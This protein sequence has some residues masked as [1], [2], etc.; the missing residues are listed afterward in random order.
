MIFKHIS[1]QNFG[2]FNGPN[3]LNVAPA[4]GKRSVVLIGGENGFGKTTLL[5]GIKLCLYG[6]RA[7]ELWGGPNLQAYRAYI[8]KLF[9]E[10]AFKDGQREMALELSLVVWENRIQHELTVRRSYHLTDG[11]QFQSD[12]QESLEVLRDGKRLQIA[13]AQNADADVGN[14][15]DTL[16]RVL[17]PSHFAQ[18]YFF[19]AE[20][21][22]ELF[23]RPKPED[24]ARAVRD[25]L[26]L[27]IYERLAADMKDYRRVKV[28]E[29]YGK[30]AKKQADLTAKQAELAQ[31]K[32]ELA[33]LEDEITNGEEEL[34]DLK[35]RIDSKESEF[36][37]LGGVHQSQVEQLRTELAA[38]EAEYD[39]LTKQLKEA[40]SGQIAACFLL[41]L[42]TEIERRI[43][44]ERTSH[45]HDLKRDSLV[46]Q[47]ARL[48]ERLFGEHAPEPEPPLTQH[49]ASFYSDRLEVE[50]KQLFEPPPDDYEKERWF[51]L[52]EQ[53]ARGL[54][55][56]FD[57]AARFSTG[58]LKEIIE[59]KNRVFGQR[60]RIKERLGSIGDTQLTQELADEI[61]K[62]IDA[63]GRISE[64]LS[65]LADSKQ[66]ALA[67]IT[68][69]DGQVTDLVNQC[70]KSAKGKEREDLSKQVESVIEEYLRLASNDKADEIEK[71]LNRLF[72][73]MANCRD[74]VRQV[75]LKRDTYALTLL[76]KDGR[77][78]PLD[79]GLSEGQAQVLALAF[80]GALAKASGRILP[81]IIDTPLG[82]LDVNHRR[83]VTQHFFIGDS[84]QTILLSTPT[85]INNCT[86]DGVPLKLLDDLRGHVAHAYTLERAG[87]GLAR[88]VPGY[89][90]NKF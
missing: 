9:N 80:V 21:M 12:S 89:F 27:S 62:L 70:G 83:D 29:L 7:S 48:Q 71:Q 31:A 59:S 67:R 65:Q 82:R 3:I 84:P 4:V 61:K 45:Q 77:E 32:A 23:N 50:I 2:P 22:R 28:P 15:Y 76:W 38:C 51:D 30:H 40:M 26:G 16:L 85:E 33:E 43:E 90:G 19:D 66:A 37:R 10:S 47:I 18:F 14:E 81:R 8:A 5:N 64:R 46:P 1:L 86:Y 44:T 54:V 57:E 13:D 24:V 87:V 6:R 69:L 63:H 60:E 75:L 72:L 36:R 79:T 25:L 55:A 49:Q 42:R 88:V 41:P 58:T 39:T 17:I 20:R 74:E 34:A 52:R 73:K 68:E 78:R 11:R 56:Q 53:D 35:H